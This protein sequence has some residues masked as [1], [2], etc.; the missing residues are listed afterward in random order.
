MSYRDLTEIT[1]VQIPI[2]HRVELYGR[3]LPLSETVMT[4][5]ANMNLKYLFKSY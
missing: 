2:K 3:Q 5:L 4:R 1:A